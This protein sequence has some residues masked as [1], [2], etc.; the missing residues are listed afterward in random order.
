MEVRLKIKLVV[1]LGNPGK[2]YQNTRHNVGFKVMD[3]LAKRLEVFKWKERD[4]ALYFDCHLD[5]CRVV[6]LKPQEYIN[7]SGDV[8]IK[9]V[10]FLDIKLEDILVVSD[11]LDLPLGVIK[12]KEKGSS[13]GHNGLKNIESQLKTNEY[14]RIKI[15]ISN[16]KTID[17]KDYVLGKFSNEEKKKI[18]LAVQKAADA[19]LDSI[20]HP[21]QEVM[22]KYN[23]KVKE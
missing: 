10:N 5:M 23:V 22:S 1:G 3:E 9:F 18:S 16:D 17:T 13:G 6:F 11:D 4:G 7:L 21:F 8:M 14:K 12:L 2:K 15:G 19:V 20:G